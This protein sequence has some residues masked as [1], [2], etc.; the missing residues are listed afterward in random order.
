ME[1]K[2]EQLQ[3]KLEIQ[4]QEI[5]HL[6]QEMNQL[7]RFRQ[8]DQAKHEAEITEL[9]RQLDSGEGTDGILY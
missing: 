4:Q 3:Q 5:K 8:D 6:Q 9:K 2:L 1:D 7:Q